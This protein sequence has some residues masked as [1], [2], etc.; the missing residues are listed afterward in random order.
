LQ[1]GLNPSSAWGFVA[2]TLVV[3]TRPLLLGCTWSPVEYSEGG[4]LR[5]RRAPASDSTA[6]IPGHT[7]SSEVEEPGS[8]SAFL[9]L[10]R[11]GI[12]PRPHP[13]R[14]PHPPRLTNDCHRSVAR[15]FLTSGA[16]VVAMVREYETAC[17]SPC[18]AEGSPSTDLSEWELILPFHIPGL[19]DTV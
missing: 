11:H 15:C 10:V 8:D 2:V 9:A 14:L 16:V 12:P 17:P 4:G 7:A 1:R 13:M 5:L 3:P 6:T 18:I 19:V